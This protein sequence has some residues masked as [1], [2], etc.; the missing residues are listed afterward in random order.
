MSVT[1]PQS[2]SLADAKNASITDRLVR[3]KKKITYF[4]L[5]FLH[6]SGLTNSC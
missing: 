5:L 1:K 6:S 3:K 4:S 2:S